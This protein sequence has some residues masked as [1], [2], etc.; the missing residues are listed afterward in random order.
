MPGGMFQRCIA[1]AGAGCI[2]N[3]HE[4]NGQSAEYIQW[5]E[6]L[7]SRLSRHRNILSGRYTALWWLI[8][9]SWSEHKR[10]LLKIIQLFIFS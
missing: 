6:A 2:Y 3:D 7:R 8:E 9:S 4:A 10:V 5:Q 1:I